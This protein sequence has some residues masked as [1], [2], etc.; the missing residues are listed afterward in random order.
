MALKALNGSVRDSE[1]AFFEHQREQ[2]LIAI[3][4]ATAELQATRLIINME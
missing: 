1:I 2:V 3:E 4:S